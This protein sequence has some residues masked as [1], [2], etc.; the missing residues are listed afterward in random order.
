VD[1]ANDNVS[2]RIVR[3]SSANGLRV[4][5]LGHLINH[6]CPQQSGKQ[7][8]V[9][10]N[11]LPMCSSAKVKKPCQEKQPH[12]R[13]RRISVDSD[14]SIASLHN[15]DFASVLGVIKPSRPARQ[16]PVE[17]DISMGSSLDE[18]D[19]S[20]AR[21]NDQF[22]LMFG[23]LCKISGN[24]LA[25]HDADNTVLAK[26]RQSEDALLSFAE[27]CP[28]H[29]AGSDLV[30]S[31]SCSGL[32]VIS[33]TDAKVQLRKKHQ[34][35]HRCPSANGSVAGIVKAPRY[36]GNTSLTHQ[37]TDRRGSWHD[38]PTDN[39]RRRFTQMTP[40][41]ISETSLQHMESLF[42]TT[43]INATASITASTNSNATGTEKWIPSE[44][45]FSTTMEVY[46]F[47][48]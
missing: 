11:Y 3:A 29:S 44:V 23:L 6:S 18:E 19:G 36:S 20:F 21:N 16:L 40:R 12:E 43:T 42:S 34:P 2:T 7:N 28:I 1:E 15:E 24:N 10:N 45:D 5:S 13:G 37:A 22:L 48:K 47:E 14:I 17:I 39:G 41:A 31:K 25:P 9:F 27:S 35:Q 38:T 26:R 33:A 30:S 4:T 8:R 46:L 32:S